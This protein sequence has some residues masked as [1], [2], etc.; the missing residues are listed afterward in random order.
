MGTKSDN[1]LNQTKS[2]GDVKI[3]KYELNFF[4]VR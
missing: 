3:S 1:F 2:S 4:F